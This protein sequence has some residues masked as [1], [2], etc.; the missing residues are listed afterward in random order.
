MS[1]S[2]QNFGG[3]FFCFL[4]WRWKWNFGCMHVW[5]EIQIEHKLSQGA[6][7]R[8]VLAL[9]ALRR[10]VKYGIRV[11]RMWKISTCTPWIKCQIY[12]QYF[13]G[14]HATSWSEMHFPRSHFSNR[15]HGF[16]S[17]FLSFMSVFN[18]F[19]H[20]VF[21]LEIFEY[22]LAV[23]QCMT[24]LLCLGCMTSNNFTILIQ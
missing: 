7:D 2:T 10:H 24:I 11:S 3:F 4:F 1:S 5:T 12:L 8:N 21:L 20:Y 6:I 9:E 23:C 22:S 19:E 18:T 14:M 16:H 13:S 17:F 15:I